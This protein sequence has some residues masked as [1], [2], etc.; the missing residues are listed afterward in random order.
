MP[1]PSAT[2]LYTSYRFSDPMPFL[3]P[4]KIQAAG[5]SK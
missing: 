1:T 4:I 2:E 3:S 5:A